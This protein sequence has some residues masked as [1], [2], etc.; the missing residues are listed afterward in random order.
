[1]AYLCRQ[2][3]QRF[4]TLHGSSA[5]HCHKYLTSL[6]MIAAATA[7]TCFHA[8]PSWVLVPRELLPISPFVFFLLLFGPNCLI[9]LQIHYFEYQSCALAICR[10]CVPGTHLFVRSTH[11]YAQADRP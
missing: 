1:M 5:T 6:E 2:E 9:A 4:A 7:G 8:I 11:N 10:L 3:V